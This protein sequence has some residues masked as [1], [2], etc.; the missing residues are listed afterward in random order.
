MPYGQSLLNQG[1]GNLDPAIGGAVRRM[2][3]DT[4]LPPELDAIRSILLYGNLRDDTGT[5]Q[6]TPEGG[7]Q[8]MGNNGI[9]VRGNFGYDPSVE[10]RFST[11]VPRSSV[12]SVIDT[13]LFDR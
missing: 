12:P 4:E 9:G 11:G 2:A 7:I 13:G 6:L 3:G 1:L 8:V 5:V 10:F